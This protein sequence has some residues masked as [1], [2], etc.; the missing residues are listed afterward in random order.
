[1]S[2]NFKLP[3]KGELKNSTPV[4][5]ITPNLKGN[6]S[7]KDLEGVEPDTGISTRSKGKKQN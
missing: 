2:V 1:M 3:S 4:F 5:K 7:V 6:E